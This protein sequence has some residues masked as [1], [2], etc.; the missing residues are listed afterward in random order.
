MHSINKNPV[1]KSKQFNFS[2]LKKAY[3]A[4]IIAV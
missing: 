2:Y 3:P 4:D 1:H